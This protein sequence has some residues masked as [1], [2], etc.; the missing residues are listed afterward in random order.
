MHRLSSSLVTVLSLLAGSGLA[1]SQEVQLRHESGPYYVGFPIVLQVVCSNLQ[2][3]KFQFPESEGYQIIEGKANQRSFSSNI[4]GKI[5]R[6]ITIQQNFSLTV[7]RP[8]QYTIGPCTVS[9]QGKQYQTGTFSLKAES[10]PE[11]D[12]ISIRVG[13][14]EKPVVLN[15][16]VSVSIEIAF[17]ARLRESFET[18]NYNVDVPL[19]FNHK[20]FFEPPEE[21]DEKRFPLKVQTADGEQRFYSTVRTENR[22]GTEWYVIRADLT[23]V[24]VAI[25]FE[26]FQASFQLREVTAWQ[27]GGFFGG[28]EPRRTR[29]LNCRDL[30]RK[31]V[32]V[33]LPE[34]RPPSFAGAIGEGFYL[35]VA[36]D[37][38]VVKAGD[39]IQLQVE[40]R[41]NGNVS[42]AQLP[43]LSEVSPA[44]KNFKTPAGLTNGVFEEDKKSFKLL[45]RPM[46]ESLR[47]IPPIEYSWYN[48]STQ[49]YESTSSEPIALS[50]RKGEIVDASDVV[51]SSAGSS[52]SESE[53]PKA[54][55]I[56]PNQTG[57][58]NLTGL[59]LSIQ[60]DPERL[61][62][63]RSKLV[64]V[65]LAGIY[66]LSLFALLVALGLRLRASVDP[67]VVARRREAE[68][69]HKELKRARMDDDLEKSVG[70]LRKLA[71]LSKRSDD[72]DLT[73]F[74]AECE[75]IIYAP[76]GSR[77]AEALLK[78][79]VDFGKKFSEE[80]R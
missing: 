49:K 46:S 31:L 4:N 30:E 19:L 5:S 23:L 67:K 21:S 9:D 45:I 7:N 60:K 35:D 68:A 79:A 32:V 74:I 14:P 66:G 65:P 69:L 62:A 6:S 52:T 36:A 58:R 57:S 47:E 44:W 29:P 24:P 76:D 73:S 42:T 27:R 11:S 16:Q 2:E 63:T 53:R 75:A 59:D 10:V 50:V 78:R 22:N 54:S 77:E 55:E 18:G 51:V 71:A 12:D 17:Q 48:P 43:E 34:G 38:T 37:R 56:R 64:P 41:G 40:L 28:R 26:R 61:L 70:A 1:L 3:P 25:T 20:F 15:Q 72:P 80:A 8:G 13:V 39:P 33:D